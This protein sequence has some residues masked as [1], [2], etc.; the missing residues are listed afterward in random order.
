MLLVPFQLSL[1][2]GAEDARNH[3]GSV[4]NVWEQSVISASESS[5]FKWGFHTRVR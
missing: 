4:G 3:F 1:R 2:M 5:A